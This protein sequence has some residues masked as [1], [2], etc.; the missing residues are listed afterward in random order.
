MKLILFHLFTF[1]LIFDS[2]TGFSLNLPDFFFDANR[3]TVLLLSTQENRGNPYRLEFKNETNL[4]DSPWDSSRPTRVLVHGY[5]EDD[6]SDITLDTSEELLEYDD[7][8]V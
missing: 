3:D 7:F 8:N 6:S 5:L 4:M 1:F 2:L